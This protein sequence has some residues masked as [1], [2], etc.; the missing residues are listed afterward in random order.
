MGAAYV[1]AM[2]PLAPAAVRIVDKSLGNFRFVGL[3]H[4]ALPNARI[5]HVVRDPVD[6]C[7][8]CF[9]Q[10]F[11]EGTQEFSFDLAEL[12]RFHRAHTA[13]MQHWRQVLPPGVMLQVNYEALV[14]RIEPEARRIVAHCGL[15]WNNACLAFHETKRPVR[16]ASVAQVRQPV[17][18]TSVG[19]WRPDPMQ[20]QPLLDAL[21]G[22]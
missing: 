21:A 12:G 7:L 9:A 6:T 13:L 11:A 22:A 4:L 2:R 14:K 5:I 15:E 17:Y 10:L 16:T 18:Q 3:I 1:E 20:L 19:R 8:S